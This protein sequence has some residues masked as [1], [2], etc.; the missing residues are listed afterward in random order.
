VVLDHLDQ[1]A[2]E[3]VPV[4]GGA[5]YLL[6]V[7]LLLGH[8]LE[9][10]A[11]YVTEGCARRELVYALVVGPD[12]VVGE[13]LEQVL[14]GLVMEIERLAVYHGPLGELFHCYLRQRLLADHLL[15]RVLDGRARLHHTQVRFHL[16]SH[17]STAFAMQFN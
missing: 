13:V 17:R 16:V 2:G 11:V 8:E 1:H 5:E 9:E 6:H 12:D 3:D 14:Y 7:W 4:L 15:D 10:L